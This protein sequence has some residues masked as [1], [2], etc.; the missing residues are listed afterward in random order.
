MIKPRKNGA[1]KKVDPLKLALFV[2][3]NRRY[4]AIDKVIYLGYILLYVSVAISIFGLILLVLWGTSADISPE[5]VSQ[6]YGTYYGILVIGLPAIVLFRNIV[7]IRY[8]GIY[9]ALKN[10]ERKK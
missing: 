5:E 7:D 9:I 8:K 4:S 3:Q 6:M 1:D 2:F 10:R